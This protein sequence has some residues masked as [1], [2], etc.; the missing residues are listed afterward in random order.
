MK[1]M[2]AAMLAA[3]MLV[4]MAYAKEWDSVPSEVCS[5][6]DTIVLDY[7][8]FQNED[9]NSS[10]PSDVEFSSENF[11]ISTKRI[12][13]GS[14][15]IE[16]IAFD[17]GDEVV[18][19][20]LKDNVGEGIT[21]D[22]KPNVVISE[23]AVKSKKSIREDGHEILGRNDTFSYGGGEKI[24]LRVGYEKETYSLMRDSDFE[25]PTIADGTTLYVEWEGDSYGMVTA[26]FDGYAYAYGRAYKGDENIYGFD[27]DVDT[28]LFRTY[29]DADIMGLNFRVNSSMELEVYSD[30]N[31]DAY[32]Y[33]YSNGKLTSSNLKWDE[34]L[35]AWTG[36]I[37]SNTS[38]IISDV[39]LKSVSSSSES[40][41]DSGSS[42]SSSSSSPIINYN[43][44]TGA[45]DVMGLASALALVS[46]AA[47]GALIIRK[48]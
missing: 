24:E 44:D 3:S 22:D 21:N 7:N 28:D 18:V 20:T 43:P 5:P 25:L 1:K 10:I 26:D 41:E 35:Y 36:K 27:T 48:K 15:L 34:D 16:S 47:A 13:K 42:S 33:R 37:S 32:I 14:D 38:Y 39:R 19:I 8:Q 17:D 40:E 2:L 46:I 12:T 9:D 29:P 4:T 6:G 30:Y 23:L 45:N 11:T 31:E